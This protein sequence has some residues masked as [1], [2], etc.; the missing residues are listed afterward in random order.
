MKQ[1][2]LAGFLVHGV[3]V[4]VHAMLLHLQAIRIVT[5]ILLGDVVTVLAV[6]ARQSDLGTYVSC[7][8]HDLSLSNGNS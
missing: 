2:R 6:F 8:G 4:A 1:N 5:T 3:L 7:L